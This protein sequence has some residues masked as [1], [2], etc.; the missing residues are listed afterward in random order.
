MK[1]VFFLFALVMIFSEFSHAQISSSGLMLGG[2]FSYRNS[3]EENDGLAIN[4]LTGTAADLP[5]GKSTFF[6]LQLEA[7]YFINSNTAIG[8]NAGFERTDSEFISI[9]NDNNGGFSSFKQNTL[10]EEYSVGPFLRYYQPFT[11]SR[12]GFQM[13]LLSTFTWGTSE[14][15]VEDMGIT[16]LGG[17]NSATFNGWQIGVFPGL[18]FF[19]NDR[20]FLDASIGG[21]S[22]R[23]RK[24]EITTEDQGI[25]FDPFSDEKTREQIDSDF[26]FFLVDG[27]GLRVGLNF[28]FAG[29]QGE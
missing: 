2:N 26:E 16:F 3:T 11:N 28:F 18:Y 23:Y 9:F 10:S 24:S 7:G 27:I 5:D 25:I 14:G 22:Y 20:I 15:S 29:G 6:S 19:L 1:N 17:D 21:L 12:L 8:L 13:D 4:G